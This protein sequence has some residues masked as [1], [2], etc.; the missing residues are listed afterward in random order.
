MEN[1]PKEYV[2]NNKKFTLLPCTYKRSNEV[3]KIV[4]QQSN[5]FDDFDM[6]KKVLAII[7]SGDVDSLTDEDITIWEFIEVHKDFF[8]PNEK[9]ML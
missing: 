3:K 9:L 6:V 4:G 7:V 5:W 8:S 2:F 1:K